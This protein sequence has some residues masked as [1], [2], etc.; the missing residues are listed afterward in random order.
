MYWN[1]DIH[2]PGGWLRQTSFWLDREGEVDTYRRQL[3]SLT[4]TPFSTT[5]LLGVVSCLEY[6][7]SSEGDSLT[8]YISPSRD[9]LYFPMDTVYRW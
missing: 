7:K 1:R 5:L 6:P 3:Y 9:G 2:A 4:V 8:V